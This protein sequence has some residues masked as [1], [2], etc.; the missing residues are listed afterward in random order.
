MFDDEAQIRRYRNFMWLSAENRSHY[1][2]LLQAG[3]LETSILK[4][5]TDDE[6]IFVDRGPYDF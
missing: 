5:E 2:K 6:E 4:G 3:L 1:N